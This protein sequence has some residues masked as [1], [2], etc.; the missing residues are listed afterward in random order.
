MYE[1]LVIVLAI[2]TAQVVVGAIGLA[3]INNKKLV[4]WYAKKTM[5]LVEEIE[6]ELIED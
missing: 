5:K 3:A 1:F 4:K 6:D 2:V